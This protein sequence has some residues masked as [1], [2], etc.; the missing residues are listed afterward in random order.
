MAL[1][2]H[3]DIG[4]VIL[5]SGVLRKVHWSLQGRGKRGGVRTI[6]YWA[7]SKDQIL[8]FLI[9]AKGEQDDLTH[10]QLKVLREIVGEEYS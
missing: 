8:L 6:Y 5:G 9:Y 10:E 3:P 1:V 7:E 2:L 4:V